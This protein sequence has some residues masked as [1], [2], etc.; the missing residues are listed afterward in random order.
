M[1]A[2]YTL[3]AVSA[4]ALLGAC[5]RSFQNIPPNDIG[6]MLTSTGYENKVYTPG[7]VDIGDL[8]NDG[9]GNSLVLIQRSGVDV[10]ES[11]TGPQSNAD[12]EDHRCLTKDGAPVTLDVRL[13]F[14]LPD[15][16]KPEGMHDLERIFLLGNPKA[17]EG[18][19]GRI[20]RID[21]K[22]IY[23]QQ[24]QQAVRGRIRQICVS[25]ENFDAMNEAFAD[26]SDHGLVKQIE[27]SVAEVLHQTNVPLR[28]VSAY[29]SN[30][31]PDPAVINATVARLA[32]AKQNLAIKESADFMAAD[33]TGSRRLVYQTQQT[34]EIVRQANA[35]GHNT[36]ILAPGA[37][38]ILGGH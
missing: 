30:M 12:H 35:N 10:E 5:Q 14:A 8:S 20:Q 31:K 2:K 13:L 28:L 33:P 22:S 19:D 4:I 34:Q 15:Y 29:S 38:S 7:Q 1:K 26:R 25:Y 6:M 3:I 27:I 23:A 32:A 24:A 36:I 17:V 37:S 21:A 9:Q 18:S 11:F 16:T